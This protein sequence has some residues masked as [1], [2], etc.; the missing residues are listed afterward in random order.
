MQSPST[1]DSGRSINQDGSRAD[2]AVE[3]MPSGSSQ[4]PLS[5]PP[6]WRFLYSLSLDIPAIALDCLPNGYGLENISKLLE[7]G[8][9]LL[10]GLTCSSLSSSSDDGRKSYLTQVPFLPRKT[11]HKRS[12]KHPADQSQTPTNSLTMLQRAR[13]PLTSSLADV[14]KVLTSGPARYTVELVR[15]VSD[16]YSEFLHEYVQELEGDAAARSAFVSEWGMRAWNEER[17]RAAWEAALVEVGWLESWAILV[18]KL[19]Q[20]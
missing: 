16:E 3:C 10:I 12:R 19:E 11:S 15:N 2:E 9:P 17:L 6:S 7:P 1:H 14:L 5:I 13:T 18:H 20:D 4:R 8:A